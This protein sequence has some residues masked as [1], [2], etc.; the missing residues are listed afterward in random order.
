VTKIGMFNN[1]M[2][3][4]MSKIPNKVFLKKMLMISMCFFNFIMLLYL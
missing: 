1:A 2:V 3:K 4:K